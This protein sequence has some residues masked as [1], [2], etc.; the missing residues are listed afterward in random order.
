MKLE[1][2]CSCCQKYQLGV[3]RSNDLSACRH[4]DESLCSRMR[5]MTSAALFREICF[6]DLISLVIVIG[7]DPNLVY[8]PMVSIKLLEEIFRVIGSCTLRR[9]FGKLYRRGN[10]F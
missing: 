9:T 4:C 6:K 8:D 2:E 1:H 7:S 10:Y 5:P 3:R